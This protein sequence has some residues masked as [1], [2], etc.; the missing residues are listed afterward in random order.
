MFQIAVE[1]SFDF[2]SPEFAAFYAGSAATAF[3]HPVWLAALYEMLLVHNRAEPLII[4]ARETDGRLA[5]VLPL[6]RRRY[7]LLR[8]VEFADL[9]VSDYVSPVAEAGAFA[10][11]L[12]DPAARRD[13]GRALRPYDLLRI[14][15]IADQS[16][17]IEML[18]KAGGRRDMGSSAYATR[19]DG[20]FDAWRAL[21]LAPSYRK[22]LDK[23]RRQLNR[24]GNVRFGVMEGPQAIRSA[25]EALR[26][27]RR[28]RFGSSELLQVSAYFDFYL[29]IATDGAGDLARTYTL[30]V[31]ERPVAV[32]LG[33]KRKDAFLVI[34]SG[35]DH[36]GFKNQSIGSLTFEDVARDCIARGENML[37]FT[38]GDE[39]YK[40]TFGSERQPM[41]EVSRAGS[42]LGLA[43]GVMIDRLPAAKSMARRLFHPGRKVT[44]PANDQPLGA[45][46]D[47]PT[48][49]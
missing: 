15:K 39:P 38:I 18:L 42:P 37:D 45:V 13:I 46:G 20:S 48:A 33:L 2:R 6:L 32:I 25:F 26:E 31:D 27:Y 34:L 24:R 16:L 47:E 8:A 14:G 41:F 23:K 35:F 4:V 9:R 10:R 17:A 49:P 30:T 36:S 44:G 12:A 21:R 22:E 40:L 29:G 1:N 11:L 3:Q 19:L 5:M 28:L 7:A 43:A